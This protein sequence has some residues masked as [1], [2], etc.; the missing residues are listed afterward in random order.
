MDLAQKILGTE[1]AWESGALGESLE[2]TSV[3]K[4]GNDDAIN[5]ALGLKTISIRLQAQLIDDLKIIAAMN[6]I[7]YQPLVRQILTRFADSEK[8]KL[9]IQVGSQSTTRARD[10]SEVAGTE[11]DDG[12]RRCA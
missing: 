7:G 11:V 8:R 9:L 3:S 10:A 12:K 1:E 4:Q 5:D 6:G 2:H